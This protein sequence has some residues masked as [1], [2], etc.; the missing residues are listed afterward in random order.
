MTLALLCP[1]QG[2]QA[3]GMG[4]AFAQSSPAARAVLDRAEAAFGGGLAGLMANGPLDQLTRT[5]NAQPAILTASLMAWAALTEATGPLPVASAAGH[6][7]GEFSALACAGAL[8]LED[9]VPLVRDRGAFMQDAVPVGQGAMAACLAEESAVAALVSAVR[10]AL[11][12]D[13]LQIANYN[14][15]GQLVISGTAPA[16]AKAQ[17]LAADHGVKRVIP[18]EV[19]APFHS[20]LM[21]PAQ[22]RFAERIATV[23]VSSLAF[24]VVTNVEALPNAD[25][26]RVRPLLVEQI[27]APV[28]WTA[29][30][31]WLLDA[32]CTTFIECG[33]GTVLTNILKRGWK[34]RELTLLAVSDP[35]TLEAAVTTLREQAHV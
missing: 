25:P 34:E 13:V 12:D 26:A 20:A 21:R 2:S 19:S 22:A 10:Q 4:T 9:A 16:V 11:P 3:V 35:A 27:T 23:P 6:S 31:E 24:P 17:A 5:T 28:R 32:G 33:P 18:L 30:C 8:T 14:G 7:L 29:I 1:G 15:P